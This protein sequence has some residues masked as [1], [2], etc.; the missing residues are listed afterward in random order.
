M[1][2]LFLHG[3]SAL[4]LLAVVATPITATAQ[5]WPTKQPIKL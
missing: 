2:K 1:R 5:A 3:L 4:S